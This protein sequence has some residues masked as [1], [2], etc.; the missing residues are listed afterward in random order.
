[1]LKN[2]DVAVFEAIKAELEGTFQGGVFVGT[3]A[4]DGVG[5]AP[6]HQLDHLVSGETKTELEGIKQLII[7]GQVRVMP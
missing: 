2:M 6:F 5:I 1:V 3:L 7:D 4:N